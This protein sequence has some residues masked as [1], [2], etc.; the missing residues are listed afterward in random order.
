MKSPDNYGVCML[1]GSYVNKMPYAVA[2]LHYVTRYWLQ[3]GHLATFAQSSWNLD[4]S[5]MWTSPTNVFFI[6]KYEEWFIHNMQ[7]NLTAKSPNKK[8]WHI[9][10]TVWCIQI[11][12]H[13]W[14][15]DQVLSDSV[16]PEPGPKK[17]YSFT[18][19]CS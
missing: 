13:M 18:N 5:I 9:L 17:S 14:A 19:Y 6:Y 3:R 12:L 11:K 10:E 2:L 15:K 4:C 1:N 7:I 16:G 8:W